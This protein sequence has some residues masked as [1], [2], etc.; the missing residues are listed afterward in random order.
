MDDLNILIKAKLSSTKAEIETQIDTLNKKITKAISVKLKVDAKDLTIINDT[1]DKIKK[2]TQQNGSKINIFNEKDLKEQGIKY[3]QGV[4]KTIEDVEKYLKG[5]YNG[6]KFDL[7]SIMKDSSGNIKSFEASIK[8]AN[9]QLEKVKFNLAD[10]ARV[11]ATGIPKSNQGYVLDSSQVSK[12]AIKP[13]QIFNREKMEEEGR[14]FFFNSKNVIDKV[15][16]EFQSLNGVTDVNILQNRDKNLKLTSFI[17]E[18][19]MANGLVEKLAFNMAKIQSGESVRSG[20]VFTGE[21]LVDKNAGANLDALKNKIQAYINQLERLK[22]GFTS[23]TTGIKDA[24]NLNT[25]ISKYEQIKGVIT[26]VQ[27]TSTSL[28]SEQRRGII[29]NIADLRLQITQYKDLQNAMKSGNTQGS[30]EKT[31]DKLQLYENKIAKLKAGFTSPATGIKDVDNL[32]ALSTKYDQIKLVIDQVRSSSTIL[33]NEQR[34]GII[35]NISNLEIEIA[36]YKDLQRIMNTSSSGSKSLSPKDISLFQDTMSN[37]LAGLQVGKETVFARPEIIAQMNRLTESVARFGTVGGVSAKEVNLQFAQLT[38]SVRTATAEITRINGAADS[39]LTTFGKDI[40]KLGIWSLAAT[41]MYAPFR[42]LKDG[43]QY[44]YQMDSALTDLSKVVDFSSNQL[45]EMATASINLGKQLGQ[46][47]VEIMK[48]MAEFGRITKDQN[49]II[50]LTRVAGMA[51]NVTTMSAADAAKNITSSMITFGI[52]AKDSMKILNSWNEIQNNFRVSAEDLAASISKVGAA[53]RLANTDM[54]DLEGMASAIIQTTGISGNEAGTAIKSF[55]SRIYRTD[56]SDPEQLGKT[57]KALKDLIN[58][59]TTKADGDLKSFNTLVGEIAEKWQF[60]SKQEQL[61]VAQSMGSTYH[62]SKFIALMQ[63][64]K[65]KLDAAAMARNSENSALDENAKKLDSI[66]GRLGLLKVAGEEFWAST[67]NSNG[68][69]TM[70]SSLTYL[71]STFANLNT[72]LSLVALGL[73]AFKGTAILTF[74]RT[75]PLAIKTSIVNLQLFKDVSLATA[76]VASG[77]ATALQG[78]SLSFQSLGMSIKSLFLSNPLGWIVLGI[79]SIVMAMDI[80]NQQ[81][82]ETAQKQKESIDAYK[83]QQTEISSLVEAYKKNAELAKT[84]ENVKLQLLETEKKLKGIFGDTAQSL[85]LQNGSIDKNIKKIEQLDIANQNAFIS[86]QKAFAEEAKNALKSS[87]EHSAVPRYGVTFSGAIFK[88][89]D[90]EA[91]THYKNLREEINKN[92]HGASLDGDTIKISKQLSATIETLESKIKGY[93]DTV[94]TLD[95][96]YKF[97]SQKSIKDLDKLSDKQKTI[98]DDLKNKLT[99]TNKDQYEKDLQDVVDV[100]SKWDGS[101]VDDLNEKLQKLGLT[102]P[103]VSNSAEQTSNAVNGVTNTAE[104]MATSLKEVSSI[105]QDVSKAMG[106]YNETGKL[107][108]STIVD[109]VTK[110]PQLID[111]LKVENGQ[112]TLNKE[113]VQ[114]LLDVRIN[115]M[116]KALEAEKTFTT[117]QAEQT[118]VRI[119]NLI[120]EA[121]VISKRNDALDA[122]PTF[123]SK[124]TIKPST[125]TIWLNQEDKLRAE[126]EVL[127][128]QLISADNRVDAKIALM[129]ALLGNIKSSAYA[130]TFDSSKDKSSS[131]KNDPQ[132]ESTTEA[133][134]RQINAQSL[135]TA[136]KNKS[137][138][139]D[140]SSAKSQKDYAKELELTTSLLE[141]Q[142]LQIDELAHASSALQWEFNNTA[143]NSGFDP[144]YLDAQGEATVEYILKFNASSKEQQEQMKNTFDILQKLKK[145]WIEDD[146]AIQGVI[147]SQSQLKQSLIEINTQIADDAISALK[148]S[149]EM[150]KD[151]VLKTIDAEESAKEKA[152][153]KELDRLDE[154]YNGIEKVINQKLK[155]IDL[156]KSNE[157]YNSKLSKA[158]KEEQNLQKEKAKYSLDNSLEG[159]IKVSEISKE[160]IIKQQEIEDMQNDHETELRKQSLQDQLDTAKEIVD[161]KKKA[162][163]KSYK[164]AKDSLE[165]QRKDL[166]YDFNT[167]INDENHFAKMRLNIISGNIT[168]IETLIKKS[169]DAIRAYSNDSLKEIGVTPGARDG[170]VGEADKAS[171]DLTKIS[172]TTVYYAND[173]DRTNAVSILGSSKFNYIQNKN[174]SVTANDL[175]IGGSSVIHPTGVA[176]S[177]NWL[178]GNSADDTK[179]EIMNWKKNHP[180]RFYDGG[181]T[182]FTG[183]HWLDGKVGKPERIL[184][185]E[186][187]LSFNKLAKNVV[188]LTNMMDNIMKNNPLQNILSSIKIPDF[189]NM[190]LSNLGQILN[191]QNSIVFNVDGSNG[192]SRNDLDKASE[193]IITKI[194][195]TFNLNGIIR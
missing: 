29:Q 26:Q 149:L 135:L 93:K 157:D 2:A 119:S 43:I 134:V 31:L 22:T 139:A 132:I 58:I 95:N 91:L 40:F 194:N 184:S 187:T 27:S 73:V 176:N 68:L 1:M 105:A 123:L 21:K 101:S 162:E 141:N 130:G 190:K 122:L 168:E 164:T 94:L 121:E 163:D 126:A 4:M 180:E 60:M 17:A 124:P 15:K 78:L 64:Y 137:L 127:K 76:M 169:I 89:T 65:I 44:V 85:D 10:I 66:S 140:I 108:S 82:E 96:A 13:E 106:E 104:E 171:G 179:D 113:A 32:T 170:V 110:Y 192:L 19:K 79:T 34:R 128:S 16:K 84:D 189:S 11:T 14:R 69:K 51:S 142:K 88:G 71:V 47:S 109:L 175:V 5:A 156:E 188:P 70:V 148:S 81:Q 117:N 131:T 186:Q 30:I 18:V 152:H 57:A 38:T 150:E 37:R 63:S 167:R 159:K 125:G 52:E 48:G 112:L 146:Q 118:K 87:S 49:E 145:A 36:K 56:E 116:I 77:E 144:A 100:L 154:Q 83:Q 28:S 155:S 50:E 41:L 99:F 46:S 107:S 39:V 177:N 174:P 191:M 193:Y 195:R 72:V 133:T 160:L 55:M 35:Q 6:K 9:N 114:G 120:A 183:M 172:K 75:L 74:F 166:E 45:N 54:E 8:L 115:T 53:S 136:E 147:E 143:T 102:L 20:F 86:K 92:L 178:W 129:K 161:A 62:Y 182:R 80:Y 98:F 42:A 103:N 181:E 138:E 7:G 165:Q 12:I 24:T 67:I 151:L 111:Q 3:K 185:A 97:I 25:L 59:D 90:E 158:Q 173:I 153:Q 33:S 61:A 23:P